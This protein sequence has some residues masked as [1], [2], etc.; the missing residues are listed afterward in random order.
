MSTKFTLRA[1]IVS[2]AFCI[3]AS[4]QTPQVVA[5][6]SAPFGPISFLFGTWSAVTTSKG[7]AAAQSTGTYTFQL[8]L[9]GSV[10]ARTSSLDKCTGP[11]TFDCQHNDMLTI[12]LEDNKPHAIYFDNE[13]H[14]IHYDVTMPDA[15]TVVF[16]SNAPGPH[17][18]LIYHFDGLVMN[19]SFQVAPPNSN[20]FT[21]Y[22]EW[23]GTRK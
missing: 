20:E 19:G 10:V 3:S 11:A 8:D 6:K 22:L 23:S 15:S 4:S 17:F 7:S 9:N 5:P 2:L 13:G 16:F 18:R 1:F 21:S 12:Y 14:T